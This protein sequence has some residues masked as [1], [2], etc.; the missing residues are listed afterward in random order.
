MVTD[1]RAGRRFPSM[2][3]ATT[4]SALRAPAHA[5]S[6]PDPEIPEKAKRRRFSARSK[7]DSSMSTTGSSRPAP[8]ER[9]CAGRGCT[10]RTSWNGAE[11]PMSAPWPSSA[12][13]SFGS[14]TIRA[15]EH[16]PYTARLLHP[17]GRRSRRAVPRSSLALTRSARRWFHERSNLPCPAPSCPL[18]RR[19]QGPVPPG[20]A[21]RDDARCGLR[22]PCS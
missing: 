15:E 18:T 22:S 13:P 17:V 20:R 5:G 16:L 7:L 21:R 6:V 10:R 19:P 14:G 3:T 8:R 12:S 11:P 9:C 4:T 1:Q 2:K